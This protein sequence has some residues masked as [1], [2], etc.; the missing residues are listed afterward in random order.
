MT[1]P[2]ISGRQAAALLNVCYPTIT[3]AVKRGDL[4]AERTNVGDALRFRITPAALADYAS[5]RLSEVQDEMSKRINSLERI[6]EAM[7]SIAA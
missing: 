4:Q 3:E 5:R 1:T 2:T 7:V 6:K